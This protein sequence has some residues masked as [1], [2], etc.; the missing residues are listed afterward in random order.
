[1]RWLRAERGQSLVELSLILPLMVFGL[2]GGADLARAYAMQ[3]AVQNGARA[4]AEAYAIDQTP[5]IAEAQNAAVEEMN[6]TPTIN[7]VAGDVTVVEK[8]PDGITDCIHPPTNVTPC[9]VTITVTYTFNTIVAWPIVPNSATFNR[10]TIFQ[11][12]Y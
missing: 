2:I 7:A 11:V 12:F 1:M 3:I 6:R 9:F 10:S 5:T 4:G 8:Q